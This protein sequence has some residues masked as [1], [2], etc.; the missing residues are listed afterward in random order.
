MPYLTASEI[1]SHLYGE[2]VKEIER[3]PTTTAQLDFAIDAAIEEAR[4]Y[5][6]AYDTTAIFN[7]TGANRN[8]ILLL[9]VKDIA[10][11]HYI[12]LSNPGVEMELRLKRYE[13]ATEW[14]SE[15]QR[16]KNNPNLPYP[17]VAPPNEPNNYIKWGSNIKRNNNF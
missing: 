16:G 5:L 7:A 17:T 4:G 15:V 2:V 14:L 13:R 9:Y 11:W 12:Q 3:D 10:V 1:S 8:P 6:T